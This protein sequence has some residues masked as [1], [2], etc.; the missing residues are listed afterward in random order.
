[1]SECASTTAS[2]FTVRWTIQD[3]GGAPMTCDSAAATSVD[4]D[5]VNVATGVDFHDTF[6]CSALGVTT[7]PLPPG[8]YSVAMRLRNAT[9]ALLAEAIDPTEE[10]I[11]PTLLT[12]LGV[13][14]F[15][16][17]G[18][19]IVDQYMA[20]SWTIEWDAT[21]TPLTCAQAKA[22]T[23]EL[24]IGATRFQWA[25]SDGNG[26]TATVAPGRYTV[27]VSLLDAGGVLLSMTPT[28]DV[29]VV[30]GRVAN[31]GPVVFGVE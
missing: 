31:L 30:A 29:Q 5:V 27:A 1:V 17:T 15:V 22:A 4:I 14:P 12:D 6:P 18:A 20:L 11:D 25:C 19:P 8:T 9:G 28:A 26:R 21:F 13:V 2:A 3:A 23:V 24:D 7:C 16:A 10:V